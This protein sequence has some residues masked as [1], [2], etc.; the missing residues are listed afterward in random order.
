MPRIFPVDSAGQWSYVPVISKGNQAR[1]REIRPMID[2]VIIRPAFIDADGNRPS[3]LDGYEM[4]MFFAD[5]GDC[6][7]GEYETATDAVAAILAQYLGADVDGY[8]VELSIWGGGV[9]RWVDYSL[10]A[11]E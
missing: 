4:H 9:N 6:L 3:A 10:S 1:L 2:P 7:N 5:R 8:G 11:V